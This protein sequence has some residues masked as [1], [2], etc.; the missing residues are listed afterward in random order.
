[1]KII[2]ILEMC[3]CEHISRTMMLQ[4]LNL[5]Y[6]QISIINN[7]GGGKCNTYY[8]SKGIFTKLKNKNKNQTK[9]K[10]KTRHGHFSQGDGFIITMMTITTH[11][12]QQITAVIN[13]LTI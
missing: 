12:K 6:F 13:A 3:R 9:T 11:Q 8:N 5:L 4:L 10:T 2:M 1:M 7:T